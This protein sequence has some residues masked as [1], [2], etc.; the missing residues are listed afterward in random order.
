VR[1]T[2]VTAHLQNHGLIKW[3]SSNHSLPFI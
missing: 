1:R 3:W 2:G